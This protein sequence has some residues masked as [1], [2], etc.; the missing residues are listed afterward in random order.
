M[1][2]A[3]AIP[4]KTC[5]RRYTQLFKYARSILS[6]VVENQVRP[7]DGR[8]SHL[9]A[10]VLSVKPE[11]EGVPR[12]DIE[13]VPKKRRKTFESLE[14]VTIQD[15]EEIVDEALIRDYMVYRWLA[16]I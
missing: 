2:G 9:H 10:G 5:Q 13:T 6:M 3:D 11:P 16:K 8:K 15:I 4:A 12:I 14:K 7:S 1:H